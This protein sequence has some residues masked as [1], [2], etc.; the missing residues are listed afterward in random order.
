M[1]FWITSSAIIFVVL[2]FFILLQ[3]KFQESEESISNYIT[4]RQYEL[5]D[6]LFK[7]ENL[8]ATE[9]AFLVLQSFNTSAYVVTKTD[10][11]VFSWP[12]NAESL[13][14][15]C[16]H[17][18]ISPLTLRGISV[19]QVKSCLSVSAVVKSTANTTTF[20]I[21]LILIFGVLALPLFGYKRALNSTIAAL[22]E[23]NKNPTKSL[24]VKASDAITTRVM[25]LVQQGFE[26]RMELASVKSQLQ[27]EKDKSDFIRQV[28]HDMLDP[29][30]SFVTNFRIFSDSLPDK[31]ISKIL[32]YSVER[33]ENTFKDIL[34][35]KKYN[36]PQDNPTQTT[37]IVPLI[38]ALLDDKRNIHKDVDFKITMPDRAETICNP[39]DF[40]RILS[41][42]INNSLEALDK[43]EK[44]IS[45]EM[46]MDGQK[47]LI[48]LA[49]NGCGISS[50][51]IN[52]VFK[53]NF[54]FGKQNG[55]GIGLSYVAKKVQSWG[56]D[57]AISS[58]L[59][60]GTKI[61]LTL[62]N[63]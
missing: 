7:G 17:L 20:S 49:D 38:N 57:I 43:N 56:G 23:W 33:I 18:V 51:N 58:D 5:S 62:N 30:N 44:Q 28:A 13:V 60:I 39:E 63:A 42:I 53:E 3:S 19:G 24:R 48:T 10:S 26:S 6:N 9:D 29:I 47:T 37:N 14:K 22:E 61:N 2:L 8:K 31:K 45:L 40:K 54:T 55:N 46:K 15:D 34:K 25:G 27:L 21:V 41:N 16:E 4:Q 36:Q 1:M 11:T 52:H 12:E 32:G 59:G 35:L 50:N